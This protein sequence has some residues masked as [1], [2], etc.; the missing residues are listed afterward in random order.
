[1]RLRQLP[2]LPG[3]TRLAAAAA[4]IMSAAVSAQ[5]VHGKAATGSAG[6][7]AGIARAPTVV[8]VP[9]A[10]NIV[11]TT[12]GNAIY[13]NIPALILPDGRVFADFGRGYEQVTRSCRAVI[14][15]G[16]F[17]GES[18]VQP[19]VQQPVVTQPSVGVSP[20]LPYTP[21]VP[22]QQTASQQ[23]LQQPIGQP[24]Q[25]VVV[26]ARSCWADDGRGRVFAARP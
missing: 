25:P 8:V 14:A 1:M 3:A 11:N 10:N 19:S 21:P 18:L 13:A 24:G 20:V 12:A 2:K 5:T 23:M 26:N 16:G 22:N 15:A 4:V 7:A 17:D 9:G 6:S